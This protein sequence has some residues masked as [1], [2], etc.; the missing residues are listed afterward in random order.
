MRNV[1]DFNLQVFPLTEMDVKNRWLAVFLDIE[2]FAWE[3]DLIV[4]CLV[5]RVMLA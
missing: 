2:V 4:V 1:L 3:T 5:T